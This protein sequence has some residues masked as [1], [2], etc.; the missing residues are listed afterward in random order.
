MS[1]QKEQVCK[2][3][4][5]DLLSVCDKF[6]DGHPAGAA[7]CGTRLTNLQRCGHHRECHQPAKQGEEG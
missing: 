2:C 4:L 1:E 5:T 6:T 7:L 3:G